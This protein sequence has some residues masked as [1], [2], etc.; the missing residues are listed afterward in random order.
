MF[1]EERSCL[2]GKVKGRYLK[3]G[4]HAEYSGEG[5]IPLGLDN[6][7]FVAAVKR[8]PNWKAHRGIRFDAFIVPKNI[9]SFVNL[10][11]PD[12]HPIPD[13]ETRIVADREKIL[14]DLLRDLAKQGVITD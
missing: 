3:D 10:D 6:H 11:N 13:I 7:E 8:R 4:H 12:E 2:C 14:T 5:A 1:L 9:G